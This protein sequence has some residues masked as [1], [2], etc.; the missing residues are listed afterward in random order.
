MT[1]VLTTT[2]KGIGVSLRPCPV[3]AIAAATQAP[4]PSGRSN[5]HRLWRITPEIRATA[6]TRIMVM[7]GRL[8][9]NPSLVQP[10]HLRNSHASYNADR[11]PSLHPQHSFG[12]AIGLAPC[13]FPDSGVGASRTSNTDREKYGWAEKE[14]LI[15]GE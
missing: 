12:H 2:R 3:A 14:Y 6:R 11:R 7:G 10:E 8:P 4:I 5:A 1:S 15:G 13:G 9:P